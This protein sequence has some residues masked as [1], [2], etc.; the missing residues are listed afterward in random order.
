MFKI[1]RKKTIVGISPFIIYP[2]F[3]NKNNEKIT[4]LKRKNS[5]F[6]FLNSKIQSQSYKICCQQKNS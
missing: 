3:K 2:N 5:I 4:Q 6:R 1:E